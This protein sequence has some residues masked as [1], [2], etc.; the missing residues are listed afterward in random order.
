M[1]CGQHD[2]YQKYACKAVNTYDIG[3]GLRKSDGIGEAVNGKAVLTWLNFI[4]VIS[5]QDG[6][7]SESMK[8]LLL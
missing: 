8:L 5:F 2:R 7:C 3:E 4:G 1:T 6:I